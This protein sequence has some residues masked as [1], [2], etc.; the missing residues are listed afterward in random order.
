MK[1]EI[2]KRLVGYDKD[3][4]EIMQFGSSVYAPEYARDVDLLVITRGKKEYGGYLDCLDDFDFSCDV[5]VREVGDKVKS[6][7]A[8]NILGA[9]EVLYGEG[10]HLKET[11]SYFEPRFREA[12]SYIRGAKEDM[13]MAGRSEDEDDRDRRIRT[14]SNSLFH[15]ARLATMSY[16]AIENA[17]RG[18]IKK[19]LPRH[20]RDEF[21]EFINVLHIDY[22]YNGNYPANYEEE[23]EKWYKRVEDFVRRL[24]GM[25]KK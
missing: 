10:E 18:G 4:V 11:T 21:E 8:C 1:E 17:R 9:F 3:I 20:Y 25:K 2:R 23:F 24:E 19:R 16:L 13:G 6:G 14:A 5:I 15:A 12:R 7:F 22:F